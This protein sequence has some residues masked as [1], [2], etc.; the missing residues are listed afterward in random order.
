MGGAASATV[1]GCVANSTSAANPDS[2]VAFEDSGTSSTDGAVTPD[3]NA[4]PVDSSA[5]TTI[6]PIP[7]SGH[8]DSSPPADTG[9]PIDA[10]DAGPAPGFVRIANMVGNGQLNVGD[11]CISPHGTNAWVGPLLLGAGQNGFPSYAV[12]QYFPAPPG[13]DDVRVLPSGATACTG[14][15]AGTYFDITTLPAVVSATVSTI[16]VSDA[17]QDGGVLPSIAVLKDTPPVSTTQASLR[18]LNLATNTDGEIALTLGSGAAAS[19]PVVTGLAPGQTSSGTNGYLQVTAANLIDLGFSATGDEGTSFPVLPASLTAGSGTTVFATENVGDGTD[20]EIVTCPDGD[21]TAVGLSNCVLS[22][23]GNNNGESSTRFANF[24]ADT[25]AP[26]F[27]VCVRYQGLPNFA[28]PF[29]YQAAG[30]ADAGA[31]PGLSLR[32]GDGNASEAVSGYF[33]IGGPGVPYVVRFVAPGSTSCASTGVIADATYTPP[34]GPPATFAATGFVSSADSGAPEGL[35][36]SAPDAGPEAGSPPVGLA[37]LGVSFVT[38][39]DDVFTE[40]NT[41]V[42]VINFNAALPDPFNAQATQ[43]TFEDIPYGTYGFYA[44]EDSILVTADSFGYVVTPPIT[45]TLLIPQDANTGRT[46]NED[47][48]LSG[49]R[50]EA[51]SIFLYGSDANSVHIIYCDDTTSWQTSSDS[52]A[53]Y[54]ACTFLEPS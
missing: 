53:V 52:P 1:G 35:D 24:L 2:G 41:L 16:V 46:F 23:Q 33:T 28:G 31:A 50:E 17:A 15:D 26:A 54:S 27:D 12:T 34:V 11:L 6:T 25:T 44:V 9:S 10:A 47:L 18:V 8:P 39:S 49:P 40:E 37:S 32:S 20:Y 14:S 7:D 5:D 38:F 19:A 3:T 51:G 4:P 29:L 13:V 22:D 43:F 48:E 36:G 45:G 30:G 42:R 21:L